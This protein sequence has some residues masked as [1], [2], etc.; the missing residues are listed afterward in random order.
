MKGLTASVCAG[1]LIAAVPCFWAA[2]THAGS[3]FYEPQVPVSAFA[4]PALWL[5]PS[6]LHVSTEVSVGSGFTGGPQGLQVTRLTYRIGEPLAMRVSL[7][8]AFGTRGPGGGNRMF[9][10]GLDL[11]YRP[12]SSVLFQVRYQ[13]LRS[14]LQLS[15]PGLGA[16][17]Y[18]YWR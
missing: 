10:E 15:R 18:D 4:R 12:F 5:D 7:A 1:L 9:L 6:R 2:P 16:G 3:G 17:A 11:S 13:D 8:N 14:P